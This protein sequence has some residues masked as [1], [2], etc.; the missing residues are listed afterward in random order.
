MCGRA[1]QKPTW[2]ELHDLL[3]IL[4]Q[5]DLSNLQP[6]WNLAPTQDAYVC[7]EHD[8][9]RKLRTMSWWLVPSWAKEKPK[10]PTFNARIETLEEK[11][12]W[13]GC[14][15][16]GRCVIPVSGFYEW[17]GAKGNKQPYYITRRDGDPMLLAGLWAIN[18]K[19]RAGDG[20]LDWQ[21]CTIITCAANRDMAMLHDRM[22]VILEKGDV[23]VWLADG[24]WSDMHRALM[25]PSGEGILTA[26]PVTKDVG[27]VQNDHEELIAAT[28]DAVF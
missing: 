27:A 2:K 24:S 14:L 8:G 4:E 13:R 5:G 15:N 7:I 22:P 3:K 25:V 16:S 6:T 18:N 17:Q 1:V 21:S 11:P 10:Y 28:G 19:I 20:S 9:E 23:D 12:T 26:S